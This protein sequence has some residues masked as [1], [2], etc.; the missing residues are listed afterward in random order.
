MISDDEFKRWQRPDGGLYG[1]DLYV[2][3]EPDYPEVTVDATLTSADLR[4]IAD[5][6][7]AHYSPGAAPAIPSLTAEETALAIEAE[8]R[9]REDCFGKAVPLSADRL[10]RFR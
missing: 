1:E 6:M 10:L 8:V 7:D 5:W 9:R 3:F 2:R 4:R